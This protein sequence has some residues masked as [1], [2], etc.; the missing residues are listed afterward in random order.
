MIV[1]KL[2]NRLSKDAVTK[3]S[4][5]WST[6]AWSELGRILKNPILRDSY[7]MRNLR[8][9]DVS[10]RICG[11]ALTVRYMAF[12][13]LN[14]TPE[15]EEVQRNYTSYIEKI[16]AAI[17]P[18]DIVVAAAL[19][20]R[21]AG[22]FGDGILCGFKYMGVGGVV[23]D[24]SA[25]DVPI[26]RGLNVPLFMKGAP[27]PTIAAYHIHR[28]KVSGVLPVGVNVPVVCDGVRVRPSDIVIGDECGI[29]VIPVEY[30]EEVAEK[31]SAVE[32]I[33]EL[34]RKL[35]M[36]GKYIHGQPMR[37]EVLKEYGL[38]EKWKLIRW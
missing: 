18:G 15:S 19:G 36:E 5:V 23:I 37:E 10:H 26:I 34:Q 11:P 20:R 30:A 12:D 38:L 21:D 32:E 2:V 16:T 9:I 33:E 27:T 6:T 14:P 28:G 13:P 1:R 25:R 8:P 4:K 3:L 7:R 31:G 24:G 35:I 17:S 29:V 22:I